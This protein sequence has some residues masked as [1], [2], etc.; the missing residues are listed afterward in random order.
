MPKAETLPFYLH[1][2]IQITN[3]GKKTKLA[4]KPEILICTTAA[5]ASWRPW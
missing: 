3:K 5:G 2:V 1:K 4:K